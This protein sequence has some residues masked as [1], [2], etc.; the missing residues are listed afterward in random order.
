MEERAEGSR[1]RVKENSDQSEQARNRGR[2][3]CLNLARVVLIL[4]TAAGMVK[5][6]V[7]LIQEKRSEGDTSLSARTSLWRPVRVLPLSA[8]C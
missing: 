3:S 8:S 7:V 6:V 4:E 5:T 1:L 2:A